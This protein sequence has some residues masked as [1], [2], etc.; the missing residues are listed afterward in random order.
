MH[1]LFRRVARRTAHV[2]G[3]PWTFA[4]CLAATALWLAGGFVVGFGSVYQLYYNTSVSAV[5]WLLVVLLQGSQNA[6]T[7]AL[8]VKLN[9]LIRAVEGARTTLVDV[10]DLSQEDLRRLQAEFHRLRQEQ[11]QDRDA[12][13][14]P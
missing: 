8:Q 5:T 11:G 10:E 14:A 7:A 12:D 9:E 13:A 1:E 3:S 6:D 4:A 2:V